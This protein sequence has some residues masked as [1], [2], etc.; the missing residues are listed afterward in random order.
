MTRSV[1]FLDDDKKGRWANLV[2]D[3][4]DPCWIGIAQTGVLVK[5]SKV[6]LFGAKL[7]EEK[8]IA[9]IADKAMLLDVLFSEDHTAYGMRN[10][11]LRSFVNAIL[12]CSDLA[13]VTRVLN[14]TETIELPEENPVE[15][16]VGEKPT[17]KK[18]T[19]ENNS[20]DQTFKQ[21]LGTLANEIRREMD[22]P[23]V[24]GTKDA[25]VWVLLNIMTSIHGRLSIF[26]LKNELSTKDAVCSVTYMCLV[27]QQLVRFSEEES[28]TLMI[29]V[30]GDAGLSIFQ[31]L[32][33]DARKAIAQK[34]HEQYV[35]LLNDAAKNENVKQYIEKLSKVVF[36]YVMSVDKN[37][38][39]RNGMNSNARDELLDV[40]EKLFT[41]IRDS[42]ES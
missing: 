41:T 30:V 26:A 8:N 38:L 1:R 10:P 16:Y 21:N 17:E 28:D 6:G 29:E 27:A 11:V 12:H 9:K 25:L 20:Q 18:S 15:E 2:M 7:Y 13:E 31:L 34:G 40:L 23:E 3:N 37:R 35:H 24:G 42:W 32:S 36:F 39:V 22:L 14:H 19:K 33:T 4:G 5:K